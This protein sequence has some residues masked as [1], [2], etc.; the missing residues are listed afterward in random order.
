L[1]SLEKRILKGDLISVYKFLLRGSGEGSIDTLLVSSD[2]M[3]GNGLKLRQGNS[4]LDTRKKFFTES[5]VK[6]WNKLPSEVV[7]A[8]RLSLCKNR[9]E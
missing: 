2:R 9:M 4:R 5:V 1:L 7:I 3:G 6:H 8:P